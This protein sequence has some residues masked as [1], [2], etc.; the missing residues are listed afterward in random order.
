MKGLKDPE[1]LNQ[2]LP[3]GNPLITTDF[4]LLDE[5]LNSIPE[6]HPG[7]ILIA[8][9]ETVPQT[10]TI[11]KVQAIL[12]KFKT[13]FSQ[14]HQVSWQNSILCITQDSV[15]I[16]HVE[17]GYLKE[18]GYLTYQ[19]FDFDKLLKSALCQNAKR[20]LVSRFQPQ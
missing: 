4:A 18:D 10:L 2:L 13:K 5:H 19:L 1:M 12:R 16:L 17:A 7:L 15:T 8:N 6:H 14:W 3:K 11:K 9:S 20:F